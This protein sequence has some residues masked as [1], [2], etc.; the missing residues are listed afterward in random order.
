MKSTGEHKLSLHRRHSTDCRF[1][2]SFYSLESDL[3]GTQVPSVPESKDL[4]RPL[5]GVTSHKCK[6]RLLE[7]RVPPILT[8][9]F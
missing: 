2:V 7:L 5:A 8:F 3:V 9:Q 4:P 1:P 6:G